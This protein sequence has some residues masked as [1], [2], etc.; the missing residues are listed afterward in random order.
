MGRL[1]IPYSMV[2]EVA[3][4]CTH[5]GFEERRSEVRPF[6]GAGQVDPHTVV[7]AAAFQRAPLFHQGAAQ[8]SVGETTWRG[9]ITRPAKGG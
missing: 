1:V 3:S 9:L 6:P 8:L 7:R 5:L 2:P 4:V